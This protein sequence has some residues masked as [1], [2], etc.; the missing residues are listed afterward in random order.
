VSQSLPSLRD[1]I[2]PIRQ[3]GAVLGVHRHTVRNW[4]LRN[5]S[6]GLRIGSRLFIYKSVLQQI[7]DGTPLDQVV[8]PSSRLNNRRNDDE[9]FPEHL[10]QQ[11]E[12]ACY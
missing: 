2:I 7:V 6:I 3:A 5:P 9:R 12:Q 8:P 4:I 1:T 10:E 11:A